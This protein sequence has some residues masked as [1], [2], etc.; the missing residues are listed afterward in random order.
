MIIHV[1]QISTIFAHCLMRP[2]TM[3]C[4]QPRGRYE[5]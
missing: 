4:N 1:S 3:E 5:G 2:I